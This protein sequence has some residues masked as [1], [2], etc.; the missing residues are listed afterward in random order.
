MHLSWEAFGDPIRLYISLKETRTLHEICQE[1]YWND[2]RQFPSYYPPSWLSVQ[3]APP[4]L[5]SFSVIWNDKFLWDKPRLSVFFS[6]SLCPLSTRVASSSSYQRLAVE[7]QR[8]DLEIKMSGMVICGDWNLWVFDLLSQPLSP[9][10][11]NSNL[12]KRNQIQVK[13]HLK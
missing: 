13:L 9:K 7:L 4:L 2:Q 5:M 3:N 1:C 8:R 12:K 11:V 10:A 6:K